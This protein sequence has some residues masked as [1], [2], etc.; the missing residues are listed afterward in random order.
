M[1]NRQR[2]ASSIYQG[3]ILTAA[4]VLVATSVT[5]GVLHVIE[6]VSMDGRPSVESVTAVGLQV[7]APVVA[8]AAL[9][10][11]LGRDWR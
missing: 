3:A 4:L 2:A 11:L 6:F 9:L 5:D 10:L 1:I 8:A 7:L